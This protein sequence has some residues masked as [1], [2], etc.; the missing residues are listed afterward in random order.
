VEFE[1]RYVEQF[2]YRPRERA[3]EVVSLRAV[4][5]SRRRPPIEAGSEGAGAAPADPAAGR[6]RCFLDG[7]WRQV[8]CVEASGLAT[9]SAI[10]GPALVQQAH[11]ALVV[12]SAGRRRSSTAATSARGRRRHKPEGMASRPVPA[13]HARSS[14]S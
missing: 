1:R 3:V 11:S 2:S 7:S 5:R 13:R 14:S 12:P 9:G 8:P 10:E 4:A 6:Q